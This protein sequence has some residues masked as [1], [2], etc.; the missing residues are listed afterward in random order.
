MALSGCSDSIG[1][2]STTSAN[3]PRV[4][5]TLVEL[6]GHGLIPHEGHAYQ[7]AINTP[8]TLDVMTKL[9]GSPYGHKSINLAA[10]Q[11]ERFD[12]ARG[13]GHAVRVTTDITHPNVFTAL[14]DEKANRVMDLLD[15]LSQE[16]SA[17]K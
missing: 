9:N 2:L 12:L 5:P 1:H 11:F 4:H 8:C 17:Q 6:N 16:C 14:S 10:T 3:P 13:L 15:L 7:Y